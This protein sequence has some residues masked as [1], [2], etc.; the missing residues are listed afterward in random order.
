[1]LKINVYAVGTIKEKFYKDAI[2]EYLKRLSRFAKVEIIETPESKI[3]NGTEESILNDEAS[4]ILKRIK[5]NEYI[6]LVDLHGKEY[7][8]EEFST[9][10]KNHSDSGTSPISFIIGGT[11][12]LG[13]E[14]KKKCKDRICL[15]KLTFTH[16]MTR[17]ILLEQL[18][19][20]FKIINNESYHH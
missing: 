17:V 16:Q 14:L 1:M 5:Q 19:R 18:Y 9:Y 6:I 2:N 11:L 3:Q 7:S 13:E 20:A 8:S 15:S 12:G 4:S 10:I